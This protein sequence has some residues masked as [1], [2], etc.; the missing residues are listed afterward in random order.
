MKKW[1]KGKKTFVVAILMVT[2]GII[3]LLSGDGDMTFSTFLA[4]DDLKTVLGG[5]GLGTLRAAVD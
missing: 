1:L 3:Q 4:S 5:I 2:V